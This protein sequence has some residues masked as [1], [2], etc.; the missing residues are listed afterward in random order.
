MA[1]A[2]CG[3]LSQLTTAWNQGLHG[4][5]GV[6]TSNGATSQFK[7]SSR[8]QEGVSLAL[9]GRSPAYSFLGLDHRAPCPGKLP[10]GTT[11]LS[12]LLPPAQGLPSVASLPWEGHET[13]WVPFPGAGLWT[14]W[15]LKLL[16]VS[17]S[18]CAWIH[19]KVRSI[20]MFFFFTTFKQSTDKQ[21]GM[22][23]RI[24]CASVITVCMIGPF[25]ATWNTEAG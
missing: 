17:G 5:R 6:D 18:G 10:Q 21:W 12:L 2:F 7:L 14:L 20:W 15:L 19:F 8:W 24:K 13:F 3:I 16:P 1:L 11:W 25:L 9:A 4:G 22:M 23:V